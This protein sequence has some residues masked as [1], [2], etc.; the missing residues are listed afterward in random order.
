MTTHSHWRIAAL[1]KTMAMK[2]TVELNPEHITKRVK[3]SIKKQLRS[4]RITGGYRSQAASIADEIVKKFELPV[5]RDSWSGVRLSNVCYEAKLR[6][7][8]LFEADWAAELLERPHLAAHRYYR[9]RYEETMDNLSRHTSNDFYVGFNDKT[10]A[11]QARAV[12]AEYI[13]DADKQ[14]IEDVIRLLDTDQPIHITTY[15]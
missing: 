1:A 3:T 9:E 15:Q 5:S 8:E 14:R 6:V 10:L 7:C 4:G 13:T 2:C 11:D 12:L